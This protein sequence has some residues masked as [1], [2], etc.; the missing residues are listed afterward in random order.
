MNTTYVNY[1][2][3]GH[4]VDLTYVYISSHREIVSN[5]LAI[6]E[7]IKRKSIDF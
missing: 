4:Y 1:P 6:I 2:L 7:Q 3:Y 5:K